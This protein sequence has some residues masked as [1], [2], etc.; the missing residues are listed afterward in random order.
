[1]GE[2]FKAMGT[3]RAGSRLS[4]TIGNSKQEREEKEERKMNKREGEG[5]R[6]RKGTVVKLTGD[7][8]IG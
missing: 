4:R 2:E 8:C 1:M 7:R 5:G 6:K 3:C